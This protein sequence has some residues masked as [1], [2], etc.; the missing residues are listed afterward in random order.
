MFESLYKQLS[1]TIQRYNRREALILVYETSQRQ[2]MPAQKPS[3]YIARVAEYNE[4]RAK[5][6]DDYLAGEEPLEIRVNG[7]AFGLTFRTPGNDIELALGLLFSEGTISERKEIIDVAEILQDGEP[8]ANGLEVTLVPAVQ[9]EK[10]RYVRGFTAGSACGV[11]GKQVIDELKTR[12]LSAPGSNSRFDPEILCSLPDKLREAQAN[13]SRTGGLHAA[14]LFD[15]K[16]ELLALRE[17]IGRHNAVDKVVGWSLQHD[18]LPLAQQILLVSGRGGFEIVQKALAAGAPLLASVSA[19]SSLAVQLA[20]E[21]DLTLIGFLRGRRFV[22]YS[23]ERRILMEP[24]AAENQ[25]DQ[26]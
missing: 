23:G 22:V 15:N 5:H 13:F 12:G 19:P 17:D 6:L 8:T 21:F 1:R 25:E 24:G 7:S 2:N 9:F 16:G 20:R 14:A 26:A 4:G 10:E 3:I 18:K 11:C